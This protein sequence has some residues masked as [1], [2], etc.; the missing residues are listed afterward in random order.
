MEYRNNNIQDNQMIKIKNECGSSA[1][2]YTG[3][4]N[5]EANIFKLNKTIELSEDEKAFIK[6]VFSQHFLL[7]DKPAII[8]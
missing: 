1:N 7:K 6:E 2:P 3:S 8:M 4:T 5:I